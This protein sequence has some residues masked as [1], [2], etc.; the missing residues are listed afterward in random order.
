MNLDELLAAARRDAHPE[1]G[2]HVL[3]AVTARLAVAPRLPP[4]PLALVAAGSLVAAAV[5]LALLAS[6]PPRSDLHDPLFPTIDT[7]MP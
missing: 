1:V 4:R 7:R 5:S 3:D 6:A 2:D